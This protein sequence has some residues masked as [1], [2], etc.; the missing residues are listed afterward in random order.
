MADAADD[1]KTATTDEKVAKD[2]DM[3]TVE[4]AI[5]NRIANRIYPYPYGVPLL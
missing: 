5:A 1:K 4:A 3:K 2:N